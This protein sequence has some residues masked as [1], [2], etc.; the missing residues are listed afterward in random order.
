M[1][2]DNAGQSWGMELAGPRPQLLLWA[3]GVSQLAGRDTEREYT[4]EI[5]LLM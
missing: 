4:P 3:E 1:K 5:F 2:E